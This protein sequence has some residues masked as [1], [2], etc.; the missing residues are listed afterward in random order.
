MP[1]TLS[2][3]VSV[4]NGSS[5]SCFR[6]SPDVSDGFGWCPLVGTDMTVVT[7]DRCLVSP[8]DRLLCFLSLRNAQTIEP[9][10]LQFPLY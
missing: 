1:S 2:G 7:I 8:D 10:G 9:P 5:V 3:V 6:L 4:S